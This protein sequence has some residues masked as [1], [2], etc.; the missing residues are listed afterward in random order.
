M[1]GEQAEI[2]SEIR[3][4]LRREGNINTID[5]IDYMVLINQ[6]SIH[7]DNNDNDR[8]YGDRTSDDIHN[9]NSSPLN[10]LPF[11]LMD[12]SNNLIYPLRKLMEKLR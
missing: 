7:E 3:E 10:L 9:V 12:A 2:T 6:A 5:D 1:T 8:N 4:S 11:H